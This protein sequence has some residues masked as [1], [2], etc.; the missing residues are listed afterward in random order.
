MLRERVLN[1]AD[2]GEQVD[3][4]Q[5]F[6]TLLR[7]ELARRVE[8]T[9]AQRPVDEPAVEPGRGPRVERRV[10][11]QRAPVEHREML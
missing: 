7:G 4:A 5:R 2:V 1:P 6:D 11:A 3:V 9:S 10:C 8:A